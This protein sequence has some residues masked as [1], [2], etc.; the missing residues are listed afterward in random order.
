MYAPAGVPNYGL[1]APS[2]LN[3]SFVHLG[4]GWIYIVIYVKT[5]LQHTFNWSL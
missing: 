5:Y 1:L 4:F 2:F 3:V